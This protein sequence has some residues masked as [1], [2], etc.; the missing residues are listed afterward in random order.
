LIPLTGV[1][2][3]IVALY[4]NYTPL[5]RLWKKIAEKLQAVLAVKD[6]MV[7]VNMAFDQMVTMIDRL[8]INV[9]KYKNTLK[10][11]VLKELVS[12]NSFRDEK[13]R[14]FELLSADPKEYKVI[15]LKFP[16]LSVN[17][18]S[19]N[20]DSDK[21][22]CVKLN[23]NKVLFMQK[24][25]EIFRKNI[26]D[27]ID[28]YS[29]DSID[30]DQIIII[31]YFDKDSVN[32]EYLKESLTN[33]CALILRET[34][35][36]PIIGVGKKYGDIL[37]IGHS[38][39]EATKVLQ[40]NLVNRD[41]KVMFF[42]QIESIK[43]S[44]IREYTYPYDEL[45]KLSAQIRSGC[46][47]NA[48]ETL[49]KLIKTLLKENIPEFIMRCIIF[50]IFNTL[51]KTSIEMNINLS[52]AMENYMNSIFISDKQSISSLFYI[53]DVTCKSFF[54]QIVENEPF[55]KP[56]LNKIIT[57]IHSN[58][59]DY[60]FTIEGMASNLGITTPY[61]S[62][63][64][65]DQTGE[66]I[67]EYVWK[68]R[69]NAAKQMFEYSEMSINEIVK[70]VGYLDVSSF[71]KKFKKVEGISPS[72]YIRKHRKSISSEDDVLFNTGIEEI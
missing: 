25:C 53:L 34:E 14:E 41:S 42:D 21:L 20:L 62:Q 26:N 28:F 17:L 68:L 29:V 4:I 35:V 40:Y 30:E 37:S 39:T 11:Y 7:A 19:I 10:S 3:I 70:S 59:M 56:L 55:V 22:K 69:L 52:A 5:Y 58:F 23:L 72:V 9:E 16:E 66:T 38:Y 45:K 33:I 8:R 50:D 43:C 32:E 71:S 63:F 54:D 36:K 18:N 67:S 2:I 61:L 1:A 15:V 48:E 64:F 51:I 46:K 24:I 31:L 13:L 57:Y 49:D 47:N 65:K 44:E 12:G 60:N 6:E 27:S